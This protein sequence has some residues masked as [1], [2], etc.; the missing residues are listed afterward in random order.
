[1]SRVTEYVGRE[2]VITSTYDHSRAENPR[3]GDLIKWADDTYG[4]VWEV[5]TGLVDKHQLHVC[6]SMG[7]AFL[8]L[9][10]PT[11]KQH[12]DPRVQIH[13]ARVYVDIS[14]GP[15][16]VLDRKDLVPTYERHLS[17]M[18]NWGDRL[19]GADQGCDYGI[20]RPVFKVDK[21]VTR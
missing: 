8:G 9:I 20:Y 13:F 14:G 18:W 5:G 7:S 21:T 1:M 12:L 17:M 19:A 2:G 10:I 16:T 6:N 15:F 11:D 3:P 4:R